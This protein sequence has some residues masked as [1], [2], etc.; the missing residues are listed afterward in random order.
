MIPAQAT[1]TIVAAG[2]VWPF[3]GSMYDYWARVASTLTTVGYR[4]V[5][6]TVETTT[7]GYRLT[8]VIVTP[9]AITALAIEQTI[10]S[11]I[12]QA[13]GYYPAAISVTR[14]NGATTGTPSAPSPAP[15]LIDQIGTLAGGLVTGANAILVIAVVGVAVLVYAIASKPERL[16]GLL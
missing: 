15:G 13:T 5:S 3:S 9:A 10:G 1:V 2:S 8:I 16:R 7:G 14:I 12:A 6:R 4:V 11:A